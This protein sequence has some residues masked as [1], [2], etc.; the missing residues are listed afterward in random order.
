LY[1]QY[2]T[3]GEDV[4]A[5]TIPEKC[6]DSSSVFV[7]NVV[8]NVAAEHSDCG[9]SQ[10]RR[11]VAQMRH[12]P[13]ADF[14]IREGMFEAPASEG[15]FASAGA[16]TVTLSTREAAGRKMP[17]LDQRI[18]SVLINS[19]CRQL[20]TNRGGL[21][22]SRERAAPSR[23]GSIGGVPMPHYFFDIKD[24]HRLVDPSGSNCENDNA[25]I[26]EV[27]VPAV[28]V[29]LDRPAVDPARRISD[30]TADKVDISTVPVYSKPAWCPRR[31]DVSDFALVAGHARC[32]EG[33]IN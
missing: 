1:A 25:A 31:L 32:K 8:A 7:N 16:M 20:Q 33:G 29:S 14:A 3:V 30:L 2:P 22:V 28:V 21:T 11:Q 13:I 15:S 27:K 10:V 9:A 12:F 26:E 18:W 4:D 24:G 17:Y 19:V 23:I 5:F 6:G